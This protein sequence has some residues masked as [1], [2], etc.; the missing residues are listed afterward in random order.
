MI[1]KGI[2]CVPFFLLALAVEAQEAVYNPYVSNPSI[3]P[4]PLPSEQSGGAGV[5]S[6]TFGNSGSDTLSE[7]NGQSMTIEIELKG[8]V[9]DGSDPLTSIDG[10]ALGYFTWE[11]RDH[12]YVGTQSTAVFP[13]AS[14]T[15]VIQYRVTS[16]STE[17]KPENGFKARIRPGPYAGEPNEDDE[18]SLYTWTQC[19][20]P[21]SPQPETPTQPT[22]SNPTGSV[23]L[24]GLPETGTWIIAVLPGDRSETGT[25]TSAEINDLAPGDYKFTV[26]NAEGCTSDPS[27]Q[28]VIDS[29]PD[30]PSAPVIEDTSQPGCTTNTGSVRLGSL[31][32]ES[33][34]LTRQPGNIEI[35]GS[36]TSYTVTG[37]PP[38]IYTYTVTAGKCT[39]A[40]SPSIVINS[41]PSTPRPPTIGSITQPTCST[42]SGSVVLTGLPSGSWTLTRNPGN[43]TAQGSGTRYT[44]TGLTDG[45]YTFIIANS[46]GCVSET[47]EP[48]QIDKAPEQPSAPVPG[49]IVQ[50]TCEVPTG[51]IVLSGLPA[52]SWTL[53]R[54]PGG[55]RIE[56]TGS[57]YN[58]TGLSQGTYT[59]S[60]INQAGCSSA[61]SSPAGIN[62]SPAITSQPVQRIDCRLGTGNAIVTVTSPVGEKY[63]YRIDQGQFQASPVFSGI[64]NGTHVIT[65]RNDAGCSI[66]GSAFTVSC[67]CVNGPSVT[68]ST[69]NGSAC[70]LSPVTVSG[71]TFGGNATL[72]TISED[73]AGSVTPMQTESSPFSFTYTP[74]ASDVGKTVTITLR[75]NNPAGDPCNEATTI[76]TLMVNPAP[77]SP[78][79]GTI[80][81]PTCNLSTGS[82]A[83]SGLPSSGT[84]TI[85]RN[86]GAASTSGSGSTAVLSGIESG[87]YTFTVSAAGCVSMPTSAVAINEQPDIPQAPSSGDIVQPTCTNANGSVVVS[88][89]P[90]SGSWTLT[91]FPGTISQSGRGTSVTVSSL[92][93]GTYN[94]TVTNAAGCTSTP[95]ANV[96][97]NTQ[98]P[99]PQP[100]APGSITEP[101]CPRPTGSVNLSGLPSSGQWTLVSAPAGTR[102]TGTGST[103]QVRGLIPGSYTFTVTNSSGC[104]SESSASVVIPAVPDA[105][106]LIVNNPKP[107]CAPATINISAPEITAGSSQGLTYS[108][109]IDQN[110]TISYKTPENADNGTYYIKAEN[111]GQCA[112]VKAITVSVFEEPV[113]SAGRDQT[114]EYDFTTNL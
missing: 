111:A 56:G 106:V 8:G 12:K 1:H 61:N 71:N 103:V 79:V 63:E 100:P 72:V 34:T 66:T 55:Y 44:V 93:P 109:W 24:N 60:V 35:Q 51:S 114:L 101:S 77:S 85:T 26:T 32:S 112:T 95:S 69:R 80:T 40:P 90:S 76:Y 98:P 82:V 65:V 29:A 33:W 6:F 2:S 28:I 99:T 47:S 91:R 59:Y 58:N 9:P 20:N 48:V 94:F 42:P 38:G 25:G 21:S 54:N 14:G 13:A 68:L 75:T 105:P 70:G 49:N 102:L 78:Q 31:P 18:I 62:A 64:V 83:L 45:T 39:S 16:N 107:V 81:Q 41:V 110:A 104:V 57:S 86:P 73:G 23:V 3:T 46:A 96:V 92:S 108:Y 22:C 5:F 113:A 11:Y 4:T 10:T 84:W 97:I 50:P 53:V 15:I 30:V 89:L 67:G 87:S 27:S 52:G 17:N 88:G 37:L 36:G 19:V 74:A 7:F 43:V